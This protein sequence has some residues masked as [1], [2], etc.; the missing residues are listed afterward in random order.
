MQY[1]ER[2]T[3]LLI[4]AVTAATVIVALALGLT[5]GLGGTPPTISTT[6]TVP[7]TGVTAPPTTVAIGLGVA[8]T[9][10]AMRARTVV[11]T[12]SHLPASASS[13][14]IIDSVALFGGRVTRDVTSGQDH[15]LTVNFYIGGHSLN[16]CFTISP[17]TVTSKAC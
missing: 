4:A 17:A 5:L 10:L 1:I 9:E 15:L 12:L 6:P 11:L 16:E 2:R 14:R 3:R 7:I 8:K 13:I